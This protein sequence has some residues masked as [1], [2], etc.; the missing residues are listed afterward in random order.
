MILRATPN[1]RR[2]LSA[3]IATCAVGHSAAAETVAVK[4]RGPVDLTPFECANYQGSAVVER[5]CYDPRGRYV[6][7]RLTGTYYHYCEVP[8]T[9]VAA[10]RESPSLGQF[11]N[12]N[13]K[14]EFDCRVRRMPAY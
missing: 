9:L 7:V 6:V 4:Y 13:I 2:M 12:R 10:W 8:A 3:L 11:Y 14:G 1:L 5:I